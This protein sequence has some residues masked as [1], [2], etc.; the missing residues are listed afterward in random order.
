MKFYTVIEVDQHDAPDYRDFVTDDFAKGLRVGDTVF[1]LCYMDREKMVGLHSTAMD[2]SFG[3]MGKITRIAEVAYP[4]V[5][6]II[7]EPIE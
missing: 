5:R 3:F 1:C 7:A 2:D 4:G 6:M